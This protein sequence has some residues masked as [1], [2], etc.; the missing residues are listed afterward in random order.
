MTNTSIRPFRVE[1]AQ[2]ELD[3]LANR[4]TRTRLPQPAPGDDW[5]TGTPNHYL[6]DAV[7]AWRAFDWRAAEERINAH[8]HF[9]TDIEG[10]PIHFIHVESPHP[11]ATPLLLLH[12][13]PGS[14]VD[15]LDMIDQLVDPVAHGGSAEQAFHLV[16]PDAPGF[17]FSTP[18]TEAGWTSARTARAYDTL[19][20]RL[21]HESY[22]AH[23]S[24]QGAVIARELGLLS[25]PGFL[26]LHVLQLFS[27]PS[28]DPAEFERLTP[29]DYAGLEHMKWFQKVGGYN[30]MNASRPQTVAAGLSDSPLGLLAYS[31]L[32]N[33]FGNGT[34]LVPLEAVLLA[35]SVAWFTNAA[36]GMTR[37]YYEN[38]EAPGATAVNTAPTGVAVFADDF[39][40]IKVFAE[41]DN[42]AITHWSRFERGGHFAAL[43]VPELVA[44]DIRAFFTAQR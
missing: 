43:E 25:P 30:T 28:G 33:S 44:A 10:Q 26:G 9:V 11:D 29:Q 2:A 40:T 14:S 18:V 41:R 3:D 35:V 27:F 5:A 24:D 42:S 34:S 8:P 23:G 7:A 38:A 32:F 36:A 13:Y 15:Y 20:R 31:E 1:I 4:L 16:I 22:G 12:T 39:Q 6:R 17:G 37:S 19:M 21:G